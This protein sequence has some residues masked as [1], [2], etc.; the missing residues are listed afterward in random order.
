MHFKNTS[1]LTGMEEPISAGFLLF[2]DDR[3]L[4]FYLFNLPSKSSNNNFFQIHRPALY[5][6][7]LEAS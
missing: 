4:Y 7:A 2:L 3:L 1:I 6:T 5:Q